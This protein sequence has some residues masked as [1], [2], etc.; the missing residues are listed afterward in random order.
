MP[1][2]KPNRCQQQ[3]AG[4]DLTRSKETQTTKGGGRYA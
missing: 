3:V 4:E 1:L 2:V